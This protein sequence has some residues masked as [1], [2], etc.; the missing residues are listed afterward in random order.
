VHRDRCRTDPLSPRSATRSSHGTE[1]LEI[2]CSRR[3]QSTLPG[4]RQRSRLSGLSAIHLSH[5]G[6][7]T[8][9]P[10][11][12]SSITRALSNYC[13]RAVGFGLGLV[14]SK[15]SAARC[16]ASM[17]QHRRVVRRAYAVVARRPFA[18]SEGD[19][20]STVDDEMVTVD[21]ASSVVGEVQHGGR[22]VTDGR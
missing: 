14:N 18:L 1:A 15:G 8:W 22:D 2:A 6:E 19:A 4:T 20:G 7:R 10:K 17:L 13:W 11:R 16:C 9:R 12:R 3:D 21:H 5:M